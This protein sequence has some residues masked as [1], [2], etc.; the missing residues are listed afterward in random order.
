MK[1]DIK[2]FL[3]QTE[4][5]VKELGAKAGELGKAIEKDASYG[6][7]AGMIKVEQLALENEKNK[8]LGQFGK[9]AYELMRKKQI[10]HKNLEETFNKIQDVDNKIKGKKLSLTNLKKKRKSTTTKKA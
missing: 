9:K 3:K 6:T 7:K 10:S 2:S 4:K 5:I 1:D 8:L